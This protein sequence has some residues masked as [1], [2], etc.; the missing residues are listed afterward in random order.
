MTDIVSG[1]AAK[2]ER[3]HLGWRKEDGLPLQLNFREVCHHGVILAGSGAG[4]STVI[5]RIV[6]EILVKTDAR[7][8]VIDSNGDFRKAHIV[9]GV[10]GAEG[11]VWKTDRPPPDDV[12]YNREPFEDRWRKVRKIH[13]MSILDDE[14]APGGAEWATPLL[15]WNKLPLEWQM[16]VLGLEL[17]HNPDEVAALHQV[18][19]RLT[20]LDATDALIDLK[21][22]RGELKSVPTTSTIM[23]PLS[24]RKTAT[25]LQMRFRQAD[26]LGIWRKTTEDV[27]LSDSFETG[28][29]PQLCVLDVPSIPNPIGRNIV[30]A[31]LLKVLWEVA[32]K[33]WDVAVNDPAKDRRP[34][35]FLVLDEAHNFVPAED[36]LDPHAL[37]IS[38]YIQRI[39]AEGR[40]Y[41]LFLLLATQRPSKIRPGLLSECENVC[42]LRLRSPIERQLACKTWALSKDLAHPTLSPLAKPEKGLGVLCGYWADWNE[43]TFQGGLRRT[44]ATGGDLPD[45]WIHKLAT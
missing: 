25:A 23:N 34:P 15:S 20:N 2:D 39:A 38:Q 33:D 3:L 45:G 12:F 37:R 17:S 21:R 30:V 27:D 24:E 28:S 19:H 32:Q 40:K 6:E 11:E 41:G 14:S 4:K 13:L 35:I 9:A 1:T 8:V 44:K 10:D 22:I 42:L 43:I 7:V 16:D 29:R 18:T 5:G 31:F 26:R 36:P